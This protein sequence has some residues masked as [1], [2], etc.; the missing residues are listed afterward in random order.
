MSRGRLRPPK[1]RTWS[2]RGHTP[3]VTVRA[4]G[5]FRFPAYTPDLNPA[6]GVWAHLKNGLG[7]LAPC[8]LDELAALAR[9]RLKRMRYKP[10]LLDGFIAETGLIPA[11][12]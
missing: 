2:P 5:F 10:G 3:C 4:G 1:A 9:T 8:S 7:S 12:L 6:E 11:P